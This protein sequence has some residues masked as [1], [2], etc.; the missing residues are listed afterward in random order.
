MIEDSGGGGTAKDTCHTAQPSIATDTTPPT[1]SADGS[2]G[3]WRHE[4]RPLPLT[5]L[6]A[7]GRG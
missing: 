2:L 4:S 5:P 6:E 7:S 1:T 3:L